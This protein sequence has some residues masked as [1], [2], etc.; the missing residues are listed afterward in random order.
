M[1]FTCIMCYKYYVDMYYL[2]FKKIIL[3]YTSIFNIIN[4]NPEFG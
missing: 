2:F 4:I 3:K 1:L